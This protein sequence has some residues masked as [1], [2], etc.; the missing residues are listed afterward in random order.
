MFNVWKT[1]YDKVSN[2][3]FAWYKHS[4][5]DAGR[6]S[7]PSEKISVAKVKA[8]IAKMKN[9]KAAGLSGVATE[10]LKERWDQSG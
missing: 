2:E 3:E 6:V 10:I 1:R 7:G 8:T 4:L 5:T 9:N